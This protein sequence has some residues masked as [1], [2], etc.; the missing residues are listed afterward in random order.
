M[1]AL[2]RA[3]RRHQVPDKTLADLDLDFQCR[4]VCLNLCVLLEFRK[5]TVAPADVSGTAQSQ[6]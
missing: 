3:G 1:E 6:L 2:A 5:Q 4:E